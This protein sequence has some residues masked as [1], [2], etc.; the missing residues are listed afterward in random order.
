MTK[1]LRVRRVLAMNIPTE[2]KSAVEQ[3]LR[4]IDDL[5][6]SAQDLDRLI[7]ARMVPLRQASRERS[8]P[9]VPGHEIEIYT[10][11]ERKQQRA[12]ESEYAPLQIAMTE[13]LSQLALLTSDIASVVKG[14]EEHRSFWIGFSTNALF[15]LTGLAV[16][17]V[18]LSV[19]QVFA[20]LGEN[21]R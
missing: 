8:N 6:E 13:H 16:S 20:F 18:C 10:A 21:I 9:E 5:R 11:F 19:S 7:R 15:F 12:R 3:I 17:A 4:K 14:G 2:G 1:V